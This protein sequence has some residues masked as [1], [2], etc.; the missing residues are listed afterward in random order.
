MR[1]IPIT[2]ND[3]YIRGTGAVVGAAGSHSDVVLD[4]TFGE[5]WEGL[6]KSIVWRNSKHVNS[7]VTLLSS[8]HLVE[9]TTNRYMVPIP[10]EPKEFAGKMTMTIKG[11]TISENTETAATLTA[12]GEFIVMESLWDPEAETS[13]DINATLA[14]QLQAAVD[15]LAYKLAAFFGL[16]VSAETIGYTEPASVT[17]ELIENVLHLKFGIPEGEKGEKGDTGRQGPQG[18]PG[19][20]GSNGTAA[21]V[22]VGMVTTLTPGSEVTITNSGTSQA[23]VFNFG[24]PQ[25]LRG[26]KGDP[27]NDGAPGLQGPQGVPGRDGIDGIDAVAVET[28]GFYQF[29]VENGDLYITYTG[30]EAPDFELDQNDG[31]LYITV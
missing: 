23:A 22:E 27:G 19:A 15:D 25:G 29:S 21:T 16:T 8:D 3:E 7:V 11:A 28:T 10:A 26:E 9:G 4:I 17:K 5:S 18:L 12:Y 1:T 20:V 24:I 13:G 30:D 14:E 6:T 2:V 31:H